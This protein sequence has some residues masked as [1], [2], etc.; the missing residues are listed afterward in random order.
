MEKYNYIIFY[1]YERFGIQGSGNCSYTRDELI[2]NIDDV[3]KME[4]VIEK[5]NNYE[6]VLITNIQKFPI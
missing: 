4:R 6:K 5:R 3:K 2:R 1:E